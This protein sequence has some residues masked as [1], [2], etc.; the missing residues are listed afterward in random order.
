VLFQTLD[1]KKYCVGIYHDGRISYDDLP[2]G[3]THTWAYSDFLKDFDIEYASLYVGGKS[4]DDVCPPELSKEW[5]QV[6]HKMRAFLK[7][8]GTSKINLKHVCFFQSIPEWFLLEWC[9]IKNKIC[10]YIFENYEKPTNYDFLVDLAKITSKIKHQRLNIDPSGMKDHLAAYAARAF[11]Q[12]LSDVDPHVYYNIFG[13]ITGRL[14][15]TSHSFPILTMN[16]KY[17]GVLKPN[18]DWFVELDYNAAELRTFIG[19]SGKDQPQEDLHEWNIKNIFAGQGTREEAKVRLFAWLYNSRSDDDL[20]NREYNREETVKK[21]Y[22]DGIITTEFGRVMESDDHH[23]MN[24]LVQS[25]SSD[26]FLR[27]MIEVDK[28]LEGKKTYIAFSVHDSLMLDLADEDKGLLPEIIE[29]FG[30]TPFGKYLVNVS[31]GKHY[32]KMEK[33]R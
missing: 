10:T 23:S 3:L 13:T 16:K 22:R 17:R 1:D 9:E 7:A 14:T 32:G 27:Q 12:K 8:V 24:R 29:V 18:N 31:A 11:Y 30:D 6:S 20:L 26:L 21:Y 2:E 25:T 33:V 19:L 5:R 15:T 4:I 28:I